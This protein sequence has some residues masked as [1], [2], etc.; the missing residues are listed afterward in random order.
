MR[1][2]S[3]KVVIVLH[4][5][6]DMVVTNHEIKMLNNHST[7]LRQLVPDPQTLHGGHACRRRSR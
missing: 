2:R 7:N 3:A 6:L 5:G 1:L 4:F